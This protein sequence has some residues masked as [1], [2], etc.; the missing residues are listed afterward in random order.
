MCRGKVIKKGFL[1]LEVQHMVDEKLLW[2]TGGELMTCNAKAKNM[3]KER[4][5]FNIHT[6]V[7]FFSLSAQVYSVS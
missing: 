5:V 6:S 3:L 1:K 7:Q 2:K 4:I